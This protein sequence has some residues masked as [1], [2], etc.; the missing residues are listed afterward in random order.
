M[1]NDTYPPMTMEQCS[2]TLA[3]KIQTPGNY[4]EESIQHG[5]DLQSVD[6][7]KTPPRNATDTHAQDFVANELLLHILKAFTPCNRSPQV[8]LN[9]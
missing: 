3:Y 4:Q 8:A 5:K 2:E 1:K 9:D 7:E 6:Q